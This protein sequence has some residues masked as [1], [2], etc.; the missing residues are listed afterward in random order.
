MSDESVVGPERTGEVPLLAIG[1]DDGESF[2]IDA[3]VIVTGRTCII[4]ASGSGKSYAVGVIC[5]EL[6]KH[7]VPFAL[8]DSEGEYS[9]LKQ[10]YEVVWVA[11]DE[12]ADLKW[13][14]FVRKELAAQAPD[15]PPLIL[16]VS[17]SKDGRQRIGALLSELYKEIEERRVPYLVIVEEADKFIPQD[18]ERLP[19][20]DEIARRG[21]KRGLGLMICTQRPSVVDKNILSQCGNQLIGKLV[22]RNDLEAVSQFFPERTL[23]KQLT[24]LEP[25][26][27]YA[28][29]GLS[30]VP[31]RVTI[32]T[33]ETRPG[34]VTPQLARREVRPLKMSKVQAEPESMAAE[35]AVEE[36]TEAPPRTKPSGA[37]AEVVDLTPQPGTP[38]G[39]PY[40]VT[41]EQVLGRVKRL[42]SFGLFG[43]QEVIGA[44]E[45]VRRRLLEVGVGLKTGVLNRKYE[46][47]YMVVDA[48]TGRRAELGKR[49]TLEE[50][51]E[52]FVGLE[53]RDVQTLMELSDGS[54]SS[55]VDI[56]DKVGISA[57][58]ARNVL[59]ELERRKLA[60]SSAMGRVTV[61]RRTVGSPEL[62][63][64]GVPLE[65]SK[66]EADDG[67]RGREVNEQQLREVVKGLRAD[68]DLVSVRAFSYPL[69]RIRLALG[70]KARTVW[71]DGVTGEE[72][73]LPGQQS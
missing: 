31:K 29:G 41:P 33:R 17:E 67:P 18:G 72:T 44:L 21:R 30:P 7:G 63:L 34:G 66:V 68:Y 38:L 60:K 71:M 58:T 49:L 55:A 32:R 42:R 50:G 28:L 12:R 39:L 6:C 65:L 45:P 54:Y 2:A 4:G 35:A 69:Y 15:V 3:N 37:P 56:A 40:A 9:G 36:V 25:G 59:K 64:T 16:D 1:T 27:F 52:R 48:A 47:R 8:V 10:K 73:Q 13:G 5:E 20:L 26:S 22:I 62:G 43:Q 61:Y 23:P 14:S 19:I 51:L 11:D 53:A 24:G 46:T 70:S 57:G